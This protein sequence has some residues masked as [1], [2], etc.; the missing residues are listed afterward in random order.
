MRRYR[1]RLAKPILHGVT[2]PHRNR[3]FLLPADRPGAAVRRYRLA[4]L[5]RV[6]LETPAGAPRVNRP[7]V[8]AIPDGSAPRHAR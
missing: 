7:A 6:A 4:R 1:G 5:E 8:G 3:I 2:T